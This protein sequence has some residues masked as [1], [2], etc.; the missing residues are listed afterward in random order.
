MIDELKQWEYDKGY[1]K[2]QV[3]VLEKIRAEIVELQKGYR[4]LL[5]Y[6]CIYDVLRIIDK[7]KG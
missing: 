4:E 1:A 5:E 6:D 2:G 7:Y 3:D